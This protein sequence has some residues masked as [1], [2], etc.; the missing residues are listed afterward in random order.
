[1][2]ILGHAALH[3]LPPTG[4]LVLPRH[5]VYPISRLAMSTALGSWLFH[6]S[7]CRPS[8]ELAWRLTWR[9]LTTYFVLDPS[10][11]ARFMSLLILL[12]VDIDTFKA[13]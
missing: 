9:R 8:L 12:T 10:L 1:M 4:G 5:C 2:A 13:V 7:T 6:C 11:T 3:A